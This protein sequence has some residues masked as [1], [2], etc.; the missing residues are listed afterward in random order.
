M[1]VLDNF[2]TLAKKAQDLLKK[3]V[4]DAKGALQK[5]AEIAHQEGIWSALLEGNVSKVKTIMLNQ[6][7]TATMR[8]AMKEL[9][10]H[11]CFLYNSEKHFEIAKFL[12]QTF[13]ETVT[14][15]YESKEYYGENILH[16]A[17][18][19][20]QLELVQYL[21]EINLELLNG[22][23]TGD[24]FKTGQPCYFGEYPLFFACSTNQKTLVEY[25][26]EKG[27]RLDDVDSNGNNMLHLCVHHSLEEMY[28]FV[29]D[30]WKKK[31]V[32]SNELPLDKRVNSN[33]LTPFCYAASTSNAKMLSFLMESTM[34]MQWSYG[35]I[36]CQLY[37]LDELD[38]L[39]DK[40]SKTKGALEIILE[41][42]DLELLSLQRVSDLLAAKWE[43]CA[44]RPFFR[45]FLF[46]TFFL[47]I[48]A[49]AV[50]LQTDR[51]SQCIVDNKLLIGEDYNKCYAD[52]FTT[53][54]FRQFCEV[55]TLLG[56]LHKGLR[57]LN[58]LR[59][60]GWA[61]FNG[62]G[63]AFL[64][65]VVSLS[66]CIFV[67]LAACLKFFQSEYAE[68]PL[69][70]GSLCAWIYM[71]FFLLG[72]RMTGPFIVM[73]YK[74]LMVDVSR[75]SVLVMVFFFGF[76]QSLYVV[77]DDD[78]ITAFLSR[79]KALFLAMLGDFDFEEYATSRF[80]LVTVSLLVIF[81]IL[82][83]IMLLNILVAMMGDTYGS[84][85]EEADK[86]WMLERARIM[87]SIQSEMALAEMHLPEFRY[88]TDIDNKRWL[89]VI[90][91]NEKHYADETPEETELLRKELE[92]SGPLQASDIKF[93][94]DAKSHDQ[95]LPTT[96]E[97]LKEDGAY[98]RKVSLSKTAKE[99]LQAVAGEV[100][101]STNEKTK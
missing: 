89:Q 88:W 5:Q 30:L 75:F 22:K 64:E 85:T 45:R 48:F 76:T 93:V 47:L 43:R 61:Y 70:I 101:D 8:G 26:V 56:V 77:F 52:N 14:A 80:P 67:F 25:M 7:E 90:S 4:D 98:Q 51:T 92:L 97:E 10:L 31:N 17:I 29:F 53:I 34:Y 94:R 20:K 40:N 36:S 49:C 35:H 84:I 79:L 24:F 95:I 12:M 99:D 54:C 42:S 23:A 86:Q 60:S 33:G 78:G 82:V 37:E 57:E 46:T 91:A 73:M 58:E 65:N 41:N 21:L 15:I 3:D 1:N 13:P 11:L 18:V 74:M 50:I 71:L 62:Q 63:A 16:I 59:V 83:P 87:S 69:A 38:P 81:V 68:I 19:N 55:L 72:F 100:H 9:P 2:N 39:P 96:N 66:F 44:A 6:P 27:A 28:T 32:G